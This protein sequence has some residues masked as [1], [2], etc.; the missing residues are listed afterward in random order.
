[1]EEQK[2]TPALENTG[3]KQ[4]SDDE[5]KNTL[6]RDAWKA[7]AALDHWVCWRFKKRDGKTTKVPH[8]CNGENAASNDPSTWTTSDAVAKAANGFDGI[9]FVLTDTEIAAFDIDDCRD[10]A[11]G[12]IHPWAQQLVERAG[13]YT[14]ITPSNP[15]PG[16][17]SL[18]WASARQCTASSRWLMA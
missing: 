13:S 17:G 7:L 11:T 12:T 6:T 4:A 18:V 2:E 1:M 14:E 5:A 10:L 8:Q 16:C 15:T 3:A 9:G